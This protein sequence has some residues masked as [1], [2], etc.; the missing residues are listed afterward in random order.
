MS[1]PPP[2]RLSEAARLFQIGRLDDAAEL[3]VATLREA[4]GNFDAAF[5]LG[6]IRGS[7]GRLVEA[8]E[9]FRQAAALNPGSFA[10]HRNLGVALAGLGRVDGAAA[11]S[12]RAL[13]LAWRSRD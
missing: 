7:Q 11:S 5:L 2:S 9:C 3:C 6:G 4:P 10:A 12:E 1:R 8:A 13:I